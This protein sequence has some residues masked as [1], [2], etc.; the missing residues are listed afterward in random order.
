MR[1]AG[2]LGLL[3]AL[4]ACGQGAGSAPEPPMVKIDCATDG[5]RVFALDCRVEPVVEGARHLLVVHHPGGGFR[6]LLKV[7]DGRGVIAA[8]GVVPATV[9]WLADGRLEVTVGSD[10]YRFPAKVKADVQPKP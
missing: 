10:R 3:L 1:R 8:D 5:A 2:V 7:D 6:R 9:A 4:S